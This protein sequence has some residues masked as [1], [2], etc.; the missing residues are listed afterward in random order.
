MKRY[1]ITL[2]DGQRGRLLLHITAPP[3]ADTSITG[4][5]LEGALALDFEH[6]TAGELLIP[7][8]SIGLHLYEVRCGG[9]TILYGHIEVASS[10]LG[11]CDHI[12]THEISA[13]LSQDIAQVSVTL[14]EGPKGDNGDS[15]TTESRV[16][17]L[18]STALQPLLARV[19]A[20]ENAP[21]GGS[22]PAWASAIKGDA[23]GITNLQLGHYGAITTPPMLGQSTGIPLI[24]YSGDGLGGGTLNLGSSGI[25]YLYLSQRGYLTISATS[26]QLIDGA[27]PGGSL[28]AWASMID[29][30]STGISN[31]IIAP[32]GKISTGT[33]SGHHPAIIMGNHGAKRIALESN[34]AI[35]SHT[36]AGT[37]I[38]LIEFR[39][40][41]LPGY[42]TTLNIGSASLNHLNLRQRDRTI[43]ATS[44]QLMQ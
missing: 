28:P 22:L 26:I 36:V 41:D 19:T 20:L 39:N 9:Q 29:G 25:D 2:R 43:S 17:Q 40:N 32:N 15:G 42:P 6:G 38:P 21:S 5:A 35:T 31:I 30:D 37:S 14:T 3:A 4:A 24:D 13:D 7:A 1:H 27:Q 10:P 12:V 18:L 16:N 23:T 8:L 44:I 11:L 34:G 33:P